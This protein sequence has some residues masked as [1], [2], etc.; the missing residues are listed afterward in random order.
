MLAQGNSIDQLWGSLRSGAALIAAACLTISGYSVPLNFIQEPAGTGLYS[1]LVNGTFVTIGVAN[2]DD[3]SFEGEVGDRVSVRLE[4]VVGTSRPKVRLLNAAGATLHTFDG[5]TDGIG[6]MYAYRVT[7][8]G[9]YRVRVY[10]DHVVSAY[11]MRVDLGRGID[12]ETE[13]ND[14]LAT[15][16]LIVPKVGS[17]KFDF[18]VGGLAH[19]ADATG[20]SFALGLAPAG[21]TLTATVQ[22]PSSTL[23]AAD[24]SLQLFEQR[25]GDRAIDLSGSTYATIPHN[26]VFDALETANALTLEAWVYIRSWPQGWFPIFDKYEATGGWGWIFGIESS[27]GGISF[28]NGTNSRAMTGV[29]PSLNVWHHVAVTYDHAANSVRFYLDGALIATRTSPGVLINTDGEPAYVGYS[30]SGAADYANGKIGEVRLWN[31]A[32]TTPEIQGNYTAANPSGVKAGWNPAVEYSTTNGNPNGV[33]TYGGMD[34][35]FATF[36]P[37]PTHTTDS[38][39]GTSSIWLNTTGSTSYGVPPGN[40]SLHPG[41]SNE[42]S[43]LR[44]TAPAG[45]TGLT[46]VTGQFLAGDSGTMLVAVRK[47]TNVLWSASNAGAFDLSVTIAA[48]DT[49]DFVVY[50]GYFYGNTPLQLSITGAAAPATLTPTDA[51]SVGLWR[52]DEGTGLVAADSSTSSNHATLGGGDPARVPAWAPGMI[53]TLPPV[54]GASI[55]RTFPVEA[56]AWLQLS[57]AANRGL[58]GRYFLSGNLTDNSGLHVVSTTLPVAGGTTTDYIQSFTITFDDELDPVAANN[59]ANVSLRT[60]GA[61]TVFGNADDIVYTLGSPNYVNGTVLS[62]ALLNGPLQAGAHRLTVGLG[63]RDRSGNPLPGTFTREFTAQELGGY[64]IENQSNDT[65]ATATSLAAAGGPG[66]GYGGGWRDGVES[67]V[68]GAQPYGVAT[69][70]L[71]GD[72][73]LDVVSS[74]YNAGTISVLKGNGDGT[75]GTPVTYAA[76]NQPFHVAVGDLN[77]DG[78]PDVVVTRINGH[79]VMVFLNTG[80]G[81]VLAAGVNYATGVQPH[82]LVLQDLN[83][84]GRLDLATANYGGNSVSVLFGNGAGAAGDGTF[85]AKV[86]FAVSGNPYSIAAGKLNL[87]NLVDLAVGTEGDKSVKVY[88]RQGDGSYTAGPV[89]AWGPSYGVKDVAIGDVNGDGRADVVA[90]QD[91]GTQIRRWQQQAD[92][93]LVEGTALNLNGSTHAYSLQLQDLN[94]DG[95]PEVI[96]GGYY[97]INVFENQGGGVFGSPYSPD[98]NGS[99]YVF[100]VAAGDF[101]G[102]GRMDLLAPVYNRNTVRVFLGRGPET[103]LADGTG[104]LGRARG[105]RSGAGDYDYYSFGAKAGDRVFVSSETWNRA[106]STGLLYRVYRPEG[107]ELTNFYGNANPSNGNDGTGQTQFV[108]PV[109]GIYYVRVD[110]WH[111][112]Y[113]EYRIVVATAPGSF[114]LESEG[115]NAANQANGLTWTDAAGSRSASVG[116]IISNGDPGDWFALGFLDVGTQVTLGASKP[117]SSGLTWIL[118][119]L[120]GSSVVVSAGAAGATPV[121]HTVLSGAAGTYYAR[122]RSSGASDFLAQYRLAIGLTD[123]TPPTITAS[124]LPA[125][126][127]RIATLFD[128]FALTFSKDMKAST[129]NNPANYDLRAAGLDGSF[130]T[131][132]DVVVPLVL[133]A[134]YVSGLNATL[135]TANGGAL[136]A[137][138]YRLK[139]LPG[140]IDG[141]LNALSPIYTRGFGVDLVPGYVQETEPNNTRATAT[142]LLIESSQPNLFGG[143]GRGYLLNGSDID[144]WSFNLQAGDRVY[145][146]GEV[147]GTP[148]STGLYYELSN[149]AGT[150]LSSMY[151]DSNGPFAFGLFTAA[152]AG[153]HTLRVTQWH[154]YYGEYRFRVF[155]LRG[156]VK[157]ETEPNN[158]IST[159]NTLTLAASGNNS[160]GS[161]HGLSRVAGDL[162]YFNVGTLQAGTTVFL[163]CR[164]PTRSTF[165]TVVS[166]YDSAGTLLSEAGGGR[167]GDAVAQVAISVTGTYYALVRTSGNTSGLDSEYVLDVL[168]VPTTDI[169]FP[170]LQVTSLTPPPATGLKSGDTTSLSFRVDNLGNLATAGVTWL[171]RVVLSADTVYGNADDIELGV[172]QR[173]GPLAA[174]APTVPSFYTVTGAAVTIPD[175]ISGNFHVIA[176]T[177]HSNTVSEFILEGDNETVTPLPIAITLAPYPDLVIEALA[178]SAAD[179]VG[180]RTATW[181]LANRGT[182]AAAAGFSERFV[183]RNATTEVVSVNNLLP[184]ASEL[185][186]NATLS[187]QANFATTIAGQYSVQVTADA[188]L[189]RFENNASG[190]AAAEANNTLTTSYAGLTITVTPLSVPTISA[191]PQGPTFL[192]GTNV[193]LTATATGNPAPTYQWQRNG[194]DIPGATSSTLVLAGVVQANAGAYVAVA[195]SAGVSATSAAFT[196]TVIDRSLLNLLSRV[197]VPVRGTVSS[198]FTIE[199]GSKRIL[200]RAVGPSLPNVTGALADPRIALLNASFGTI[201]SNDNWGANA[202]AADITTAT[203]GLGLAPGL[204][205]GGRDA[206]LLVT[207]TPGTYT[208]VLDGVGGTGGM[209][210]FDVVDADSGLW[211]R[212]AMLALRTAVTETSN[213]VVGFNLTG[214]TE[215]K[216]L[217]RALG[218]TLGPNHA[219]TNR[220][221]IDPY[222]YLYRGETEIGRND[223]SS[224]DAPVDAATALVGAMPR[225]GR[226][227]FV[228][229]S[230]N[231]DST[232]F[233][234]L[235]PGS[236]TARV[237]PYATSQSGEALFEIFPVDDLRPATI[238]P[239]LTYVSANQ[240]AVLQGD[241]TLAVVVVAKPPATFQWRRYLNSVATP[242]SGATASVLR[243]SNL[244]QADSGA[245]YDVVITS[246]AATIT[247]P[248]RT[249]TIL[250][251]FHSAD[252]LPAGNPDNL[253]GVDELLRVGQLSNFTTGGVVSGEYHTQAGTEDGFALG[254][255]VIIKHHSADT[256]RDGRIDVVELARVIQLFQYADGTVRT[257]QY[258]ARVGTE[259]GFAPGPVPSNNDE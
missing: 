106:S 20:D 230:D 170:N 157:V 48:G 162:D 44:W 168:V 82:R 110:Q 73:K 152:D 186:A 119:V 154:G 1:A 226:Y 16:N 131:A 100:G 23:T 239:A 3:W 136:P 160:S 112:Y 74:N 179:G 51:G 244:L 24:L 113:G 216:Y 39:S 247:S 199:G 132:D 125:E 46:K 127:G 148:A 65:F 57:T 105:N 64:R 220:V 195:S 256:N 84:D 145:V 210:Q 255:G 223:D 40:I 122:I 151:A 133:N 249:V 221:L 33:W 123:T 234:P 99:A 9:T 251:A 212:L 218:P 58:S 109:T 213:L 19:A 167:S 59:L 259:D 241:A 85:A 5:G 153:A 202:N 56:T 229:A 206:A 8:P 26:A 227:N 97:N 197:T 222:L 93:T 191:Q 248:Q 76:P 228:T 233:L 207:L 47:G 10:T 183:V 91:Y 211:P 88:N 166:L 50:G 12:L 172:F 190:H 235:S 103:M 135:R 13:D 196:L 192:T 200:L 174:A 107:T 173:T 159:S 66:A 108:A 114:D 184:V 161:M 242:I 225:I 92:G 217:I 32:L 36:T 128:R 94:G 246:G 257:G 198:S 118:D 25:T 224:E 238:A 38:W 28:F 21:S 77:N 101:N 245:A 214:A 115:N 15:A 18:A 6:V 169:S 121:S 175:G 164:L 204:T 142:P 243:L 60:S 237:R 63:M 215:R 181:T 185:A 27:G 193:T 2:A 120:N 87:D 146:Q 71:D 96:S 250:S 37:H 68:G 252:F 111:A 205:I 219:G 176:R 54:A 70:D 130:D 201:N 177:D 86:D 232:L 95:K 102:D 80:T 209:A 149:P 43:V 78:K 67:A 144:F 83:G 116:G 150:A 30:P 62:F 178:V 187:R 61:D 141:F 14:T 90:V 180:N 156:D 254:P 52:F 140:L 35:G 158:G 147:P 81:G 253:I 55:N 126:G 165:Q 124:T 41:A 163:S 34:T 188:Q 42:P 117:D 240:D 189:Q 11:A 17:G 155:I 29:V 4:A 45:Y 7:T 208:A 143:G 138:N 98:M 258:H 49:L 134:A 89:F 69:A 79:A 75:F 31:R 72:G 203:S 171:D 104:T 53:R 137:G 236:Y 194:L 22:L 182:G 139:A 231:N 129:V